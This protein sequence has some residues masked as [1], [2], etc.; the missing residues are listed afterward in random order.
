MS[1]PP[2][3]VGSIAWMAKWTAPHIEPESDLRVTF[4][5]EQQAWRSDFGGQCACFFVE[6]S[7]AEVSETS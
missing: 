3:Q 4:Y 7:L 2:N 5:A 6:I 1:F